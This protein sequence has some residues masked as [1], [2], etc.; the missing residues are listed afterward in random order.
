MLA[1]DL[2]VAC[3]PAAAALAYHVF[4]AVAAI[5]APIAASKGWKQQVLLADAVG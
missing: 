5:A 4:A 1:A 3:V 2:A